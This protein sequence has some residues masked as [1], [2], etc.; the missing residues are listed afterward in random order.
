MGEVL[1]QRPLADRL[2]VLPFHDDL[3]DLFLTEPEADELLDALAI[4]ARRLE[5][6]AASAGAR[7]AMGS[8]FLAG[9]RGHSS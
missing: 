8:L 2:P 5:G 3:S 9:G 7:A 6:L 4:A 1:A